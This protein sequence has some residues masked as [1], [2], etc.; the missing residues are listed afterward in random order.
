MAA[1]IA[2]CNES[3]DEGLAESTD[4]SAWWEDDVQN[5]SV[6]VPESRRCV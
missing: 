2:V 4:E 5:P 3:G 1:A 6:V